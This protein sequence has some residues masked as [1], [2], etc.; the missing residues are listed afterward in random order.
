MTDRPILF[1][2]PMVQALLADRKTQTR[3]ILKPQPGSDGIYPD[4]SSAKKA[5]RIVR[6]DRLWVREAWRTSAGVDDVAPSRLEVPGGGYGWPIWYDA[7]SGEV[8]WRGSQTGGP[9]FTAPGKL[10][11]S[12]FMPRW[13][14]RLTLTV[15]EVRVQ[16]L[17][18]L[19]AE[20]AAAEGLIQ[21]SASKRW[22][23]ER[24]E[25]YFGCAHHDPRAVY[26]ML[27]ERINGADSWA[28]NPWV[29]AYTFT[30]ERR[31]SDH[32]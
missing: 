25:Q 2:G 29:A 18:E 5:L 19:S 31:N 10:R 24:G 22:V 1:S 3:R 32:G 17:Q 21:L 13:A 30:V 12:M 7:D 26:E 20:D 23:I 28:A 27:W 15:T 14:S 8:T 9:S 4:I 11:P 16:R 6:G